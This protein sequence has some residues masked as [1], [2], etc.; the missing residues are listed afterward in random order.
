MVLGILALQGFILASLLY[1]NRTA[2]TVSGRMLA[3]LVGLFSMILM[4]EAMEALRWHQ[5]FPRI[6]GSGFFLDLFIGPLTLIY[7][8]ALMTQG[9][10]STKQYVLHLA[11]PVL[12]NMLY[13][14]YHLMVPWQEHL[15]KDPSLS[16]Q[17]LFS[18]SVKISYQVIYLGTVIILLTRFLKNHVEGQLRT[19][20]WLRNILSAVMVLIPLVMIL[21]VVRENF[22]IESD[23]ATSIIMIL[24]IYSI[25]YAALMDPQVYPRSTERLGKGTSGPLKKYQTSSLSQTEKREWADRIRL[26]MDDKKPFL[27]AALSLDELAAGLELRGHDLSQIL[28]EQF[29][30]NFYDFVNSYRIQEIMDRLKAQEHLKK[31]LLAIALESGF[32]SKATFN[33]SFKKITGMTPKQFIAKD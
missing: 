11:W 29:D 31:N 19:V 17:L 20:K 14:P 13:L 6:T 24:S 21:E 23:D 33:R 5:S 4:E 15:V 1:F 7:A 12:V 18:I 32:N 28:N 8:Q 22:P 27:K 2:H 25:G 10:V 30:Q 26:F 16:D 9:K 3:I